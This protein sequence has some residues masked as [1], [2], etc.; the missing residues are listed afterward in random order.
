MFTLAKNS[1]WGFGIRKIN[2]GGCHFLGKGSFIYKNLKGAQ[3]Q[4]R[5]FELNVNF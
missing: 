1:D 4:L 5:N 2:G 3:N